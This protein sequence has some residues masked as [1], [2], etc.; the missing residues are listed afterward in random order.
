M[1]KLL[2]TTMTALLTTPMMLSSF[3]QSASA[4]TAGEA[5]GGVLLGIGAAVMLDS[6]SSSDSSGQQSSDSI[7]CN[8]QNGRTNQCSFNTRNGVRLVEQLSNTSCNGN[9]S[10]GNGFIEVRNG[11][12]AKFARNSNNRNNNTIIN[13]PSRSNQNSIT[14]SSERGRN[15][16]CNFNTQRGVV[17]VRQLSKT[18][19][20]GNW[21]YGRGY[22]EVRNGCRAE[23][24]QDNHNQVS[25]EREYDRGF[26]HARKGKPY[27]NRHNSRA[28]DRGYNDGL[29]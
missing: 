24:A 13:S 21:G 25:R 15:Q 27:N 2:A 4:L 7:V 28:Y 12:R 17:L 22:I 26:R 16:R 3:T 9:W 8:S 23:F 19:C 5:I 10:Y 20:Q 14:C 11:C 6:D 18:S 29:N 1:K